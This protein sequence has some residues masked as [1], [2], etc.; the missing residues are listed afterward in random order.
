MRNVS[1]C[2][3]VFTILSKSPTV[4]SCRSVKLDTQA[5]VSHLTLSHSTLSMQPPPPPLLLLLLPCPPQTPICQI[6]IRLSPPLSPLHPAPPLPLRFPW[7]SLHLV[8]CV[9]HSW[10]TCY[11]RQT[12]THTH[13]LVIYT[14]DSQMESTRRP[15][16]CF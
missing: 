4:S 14:P 13:K 15:R 10:P 12:H 9:S 11:F 3:C 2:M 6:S 8:T 16:L 1:H 7:L 5:F